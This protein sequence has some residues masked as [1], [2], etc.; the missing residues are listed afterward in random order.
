E[1][2]V[3]DVTARKALEAQLRQSQ[4]MEAIG[5]LAGGVAH[6]FNNLLTVIIGC[7]DLLHSQENIDAAARELIN[8]IRKA[9]N[10]AA[11]LPHQLLAFSRKQI[12]QPETLRINSLVADTER[13]LRRLI[14]E[15]IH[16]STNLDPNIGFIAADPVL[17]EQ[18]ILNLA[19]NARDAMPQGGD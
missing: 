1:G 16:L 10:R 13:M 8:E 14:G 18:I 6:D 9:A 15:N 3:E 12:L 11:T 7:S 19:V 4:K 17:L 2:F 5:L